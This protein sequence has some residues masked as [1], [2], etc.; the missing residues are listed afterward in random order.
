MI[1]RNFI[2]PLF[3]KLIVGLGVNKLIALKYALKIIAFS[4][5]SEQ[6]LLAMNG[7]DGCHIIINRNTTSFRT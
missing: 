4:T 7:S 5:A 2:A 1:A 3:Y 6:S